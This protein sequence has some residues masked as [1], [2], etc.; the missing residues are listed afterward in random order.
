MGGAQLLTRVVP[1]AV[2]MTDTAVDPDAAG[3]PNLVD[4][5]AWD[6]RGAEVKRVVREH[7][8]YAQQRKVIR[9]CVRAFV[10]ERAE[11][12]PFQC[13]MMSRTIQEGCEQHAA[14]LILNESKDTLLAGFKAAWPLKY[15]LMVSSNVNFYEMLPWELKRTS[16]QPL[17][18]TTLL[19]L[20]GWPSRRWAQH[21]DDEEFS[22]AM[23][24]AQ[25][26]DGWTVAVD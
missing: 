5:I 24:V 10:E 9:E 12:S 15:A 2:A 7:Q 19:S 3:T 18:Q 4:H 16:A 8:A 20:T 23:T 25:W 22:P 6:A 14:A 1:W 11:Q 17:Q 26:M 21:P 13:D